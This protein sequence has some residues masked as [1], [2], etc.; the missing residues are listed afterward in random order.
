[1]SDANSQK[2]SHRGRIFPEIQWSTEEKARKSAEQNA[3]YQR[4]RVIFDLIQTQLIAEHYGWYVAVEPESGD[5]FLDR[6]AETAS[7]K[8]RQQY[9]QRIHCLFCLNETGAC[10]TI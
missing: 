4:C 3:F 2:V 9:P 6:D 7:Q 5:Y 1:M 8:A 10:G